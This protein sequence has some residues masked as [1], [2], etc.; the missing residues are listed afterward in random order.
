MLT[1][2]LDYH[3]PPERIATTPAEPRDA[4]RLMVVHRRHNRIEHRHVRD[5][6]DLGLGPNDLLVFNHSRVLPAFFEGV[7]HGTGGKITG[8]YLGAPAPGLWHVMLESRGS[9]RTGESVRL[10]PDA[11]LELVTRLG[12]GQWHA[13]LHSPQG[14]L[15]LLQRVGSTPLPPYIR[16]RRQALA[17]PLHQPDD[18]HR[19]NTVYAAEP[20]SVAAPTAGLHFTAPLLRQLDSLGVARAFVTLHV[21]LGTFAPVRTQRVEDHPIHS[22]WV[23]IPPATLAALARTR[24]NAGRIIP[25][26]TTTVRALE[27]LPDPLPDP[28][29]HPG[30]FST[31]TRLFITPPDPAAGTPGFRFRFA[32]G[33]MTN[34]HLPCST[35]LA[36]VAALPEVGLDRL[37]QWYQLAID[38]EYRFYSFGDAM[39]LL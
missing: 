21:G 27:S 20:G 24:A 9:L 23:S 38:H 30:P 16:K 37:K 35:L 11:A 28:P 7:R 1:Q 31:D 34:F 36:L 25:V 5:L 3:L 8:L 12:A 6:P 18:A 39:L 29:L 22:E 14:T 13:R 26:G 4:A 33:L 10:A 32:D 15:D 19:Y 17:Q 2:E